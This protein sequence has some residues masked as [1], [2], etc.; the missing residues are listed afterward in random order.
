MEKTILIQLEDFANH[1][2]FDL[3]AKYCTACVTFAVRGCAKWNSEKI[4]L[5]NSKALALISLVADRRQAAAAKD[6]ILGLGE[7][8]DNTEQEQPDTNTRSLEAITNPQPTSEEESE[9]DNDQ[10][11]F[12]MDSQNPFTTFF[13]SED[14][15][16]LA[17]KIVQGISDF[18]PAACAK[19]A[20]TFALN[21]SL[22][23]DLTMKDSRR[24]MELAKQCSEVPWTLPE[25]AVLDPD[26]S[27]PPMQAL[28]EP[29]T[30]DAAP[31]AVSDVAPQSAVAT[32]ETSATKGPTIA[33]QHTVLALPLAADEPCL[34]AVPASAPSASTA[35]DVARPSVT[36][37]SA[38]TTHPPVQ[39]QAPQPLAVTDGSLDHAT[40]APVHHTVSLRPLSKTDA[41]IVASASTGVPKTN[42]A[43]PESGV[44]SVL[45]SDKKVL[46]SGSLNYQV[47]SSFS[48]CSKSE[49]K[50]LLPFPS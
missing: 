18:N 20:L 16:T 14:R 21:P 37:P 32:A 38:A 8:D 9:S 46:S 2:A 6:Q 26:Q 25:S 48:L 50:V 33:Q 49:S 5:V 12:L 22:M 29:R 31:A 42:L 34:S 45:F 27:A 7:P 15:L 36:P 17:R 4:W 40:A 43:F 30:A 28:A 39:Q 3:L 35:L 13:T 24:I 47:P 11:Q 41:L 10:D 44:S 19:I 1:N 23:D